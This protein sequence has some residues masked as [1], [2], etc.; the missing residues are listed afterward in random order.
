MR[1]KDVVGKGIFVGKVIV[2]PTETC[3]KT[4]LA[5]N[6]NS[7]VGPVLEVKVNI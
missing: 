5:I 2:R 4:P 3:S 6:L 7:S 1:Y